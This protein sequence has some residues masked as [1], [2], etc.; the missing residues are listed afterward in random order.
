MPSRPARRSSAGAVGRSKCDSRQPVAAPRP[1]LLDEQQPRG[2]E[3]GAEHRVA[4]QLG[5]QR[6]A[7]ERLARVRGAVAS[8]RS[9]RRR[10][11]PSRSS[12]RA[13]TSCSS[14][15]RPGRS[16]GGERRAGRARVF[17]A[18]SAATGQRD[19]RVDQPE[20]QLV[21]AAVQPHAQARAQP[22]RRRRRRAR[23]R[24]PSA[25]SG[26]DRLR[27]GAVAQVGGDRGRR[28]PRRG[29]ASSRSVQSRER[30]REA[31]ARARPG[32]RGRRP[33]AATRRSSGSSWRALDAAAGR[34][35]AA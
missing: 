13:R 15:S 12:R 28:R 32:R 27:P 25:A 1:G 4:A 20:P 31:R 2:R 16:A 30:W 34:A 11:M 6:A 7:V 17:S 5:A 33:S 9:T 29:V 3:R 23:R 26:A 8:R 22:Q 24:P 19:G 21:L 10:A 14:A 18:A 35:G